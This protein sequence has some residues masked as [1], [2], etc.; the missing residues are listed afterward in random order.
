MDKL[1][2]ISA[3]ARIGKNVTIGPFT[4]IHDNVQLG[5]NTIIDSHCVIG[6]PTALAQGKHLIIGP[7]SHIRS[8]SVFYEGSTFGESLSTG[9]GV[10]VRENTI[11]GDGVQFGSRS[12]IQGDCKIGNYVKTHSEVHIGKG[13]TIGDFVYI[14]PRVQFTNDPFP[15][16]FITEETNIKDMCVIATGTILL[17]GISVGLCSFIGAGSLVRNDI[18]DVSAATG[19]PAEVFCR[20]DQFFNLKHSLFFPWINNFKSKYPEKA[21][22]LIEQILE[23]VYQKVAEAKTGN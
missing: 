20:I 8:H 2:K 17:P 11:G 12:D 3:R 5:D 23:K 18:P 4:V 21:Y 13:S 16:S 19:N 1:T 7:D 9:H 14:S 22:P 10:Q 6:Y 15:P